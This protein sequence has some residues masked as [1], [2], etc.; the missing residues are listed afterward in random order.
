MCKVG[1]LTRK[2]IKKG[3]Y[4]ERHGSRHDIYRHPKRTEQL[5]IPRH[6]GKELPKGTFNNILKAAGLK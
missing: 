1:S 5:T 6:P 3:W 2:I 4:L